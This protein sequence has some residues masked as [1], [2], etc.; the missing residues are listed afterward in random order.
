M[1]A[2]SSS[3]SS[4][5]LSTPIQFNHATYY[6]DNV[7]QLTWLQILLNH[8]TA[9]VL[10]QHRIVNS[11]PL[12]D[13]SLTIVF[14]VLLYRLRTF[15]TRK[16]YVPIAVNQLGLHDKKDVLRFRENAW[17]TT[18]YVFS[19]IVG[20]LVM[21]QSDWIFNVY[22]VYQG[23]PH[24]GSE[25]FLFREYYILGGAFYLQ[26][27]YSLLFIDEKM[28]D[29]Y[30]MVIHHIATISLIVLSLAT[31]HHRIGSL[32]LLLHDIVDIFLYSAKGCHIVQHSTFQTVANVL[33][34]IF[35]V[36]FFALRLVYFPWMIGYTVWHPFVS[37][38]P[39]KQYFFRYVPNA[40]YPFELSSYGVCAFKYC[41]STY[42]LLT[43]ELCLLLVL[44]INWFGTILKILFTTLKEMK[45]PGDIRAKDHQ[46]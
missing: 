8:S 7:E 2:T 26:A 43:L 31:C 17:F 39:S 13:I 5:S 22:N 19:A 6:T 28:K 41:I 44:H 27:L 1:N 20:L 15:L 29:F 23:F 12:Y 24:T 25:V 32:V 33:F 36:T 4:S 21:S 38:I 37:S 14:A 18:Y 16:L 42:N 3:S 46:D 11:L 9:P 30:E 10:S 35:T 34:A 45:N 40:Y